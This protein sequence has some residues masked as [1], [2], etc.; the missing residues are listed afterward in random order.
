MNI[1][2]EVQSQEVAQEAPEVVEEQAV[3][4]AEDN[5]E[6]E[7]ES[8][9][10]PAS[11]AELNFKKLREEAARAKKERDEAVNYLRQIEMY[12][13]QQQQQQKQ[14]P[15][16]QKDPE[17]EIS[18]SD[19]DLLEGR[20]LKKEIGRLKKQMDG[21]KK[22]YEESA[23]EQKVVS[24]F[25]DFYD[26]VNQD[27][28]QALKQADPELAESL[29]Y[30]PNMYTKAVS[31]YKQIKRL[32]LV[33]EDNYEVEKTIAHKNIRKPRPTSSISPQ[34]GDSPLSKANAFSGG[35][36]PELK[37]QLYQDMVKKARGN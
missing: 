10:A 1:E 29:H 22:Q 18:Y 13:Y 12:A 36:T 23:I 4:Q 16:Q 9:D 2:E 26:V 14:V 11:D 15:Q 27:T 24:K 7:Q 25:P 31:T 21:Y 3:E 19:D 33:P 6:V 37:R 20:H 32:G 34:S 35:L 8:T 5:Q 28:I 17:D 30:N